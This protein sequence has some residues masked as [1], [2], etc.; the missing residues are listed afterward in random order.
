MPLTIS[1][2]R[3]A[4][5]FNLFQ[6]VRGDQDGPAFVCQLAHEVVKLEALAG[7]GAVQRLIEDDS[8]GFVYDGCRQPH[9]LAHPARV[10][11][12]RSVLRVG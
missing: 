2:M 8:L 9:A 6:D 12:E 1:S 5:V 10:R 3:S 11:A 4:S 7:V